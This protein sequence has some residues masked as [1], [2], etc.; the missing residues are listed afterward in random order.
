MGL[1]IHR[2]VALIMSAKPLDAIV[3]QPTTDS[4]DRMMEQMAQMVTPVKTTA[5]GGLHGSLTLIFDDADYA[6]VTK[7]IVTSS[8]PLNKPTMINPRIN[9]LS[10]PYEILTLQEEMKTLQKDVDLQEAVTTIQVQH[11]IDIVE[12]QYVEGLNKDYFGY[13]NQIIKKFLTHLRMSWCMV[14]MKECTD[15][16]VAFYQAWVPL[17]THIITFCCQLNKQQ[18]K[19]KNINIIILEEA[20][21]LH[22][23]G[24]MYKSNYYTKKQMT[25]YQ[26]QIDVNQTWLHTLQISPNFLPSARPIETI[27][28]PTTVLTVQRTPTTSQPIAALSPPPVTLPPAISTL[29]A[30]RQHFRL[31]GSMLPRS[32]PLPQSNWTQRPYYTQNLTPNASNL[33]SS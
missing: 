20:K 9:K 13:A 28:W 26:M 8:A 29:R 24:Q 11:I 30:L 2:M 3:G 12:E 16:T 22:F 4:M 1:T 18:K 10:N 25:K 7:N 17:T 23:G 27:M 14:M 6:M 21:T 32:A 33:A 5:W 31:R 19:C 15:A